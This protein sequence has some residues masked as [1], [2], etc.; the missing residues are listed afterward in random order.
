MKIID[1]KVREAVYSRGREVSRTRLTQ[2]WDDFM[3]Y[4]VLLPVQ[5]LTHTPI[6][7][8]QVS[9]LSIITRLLVAVC[10]SIGNIWYYA[11]GIVFI[12]ISEIGDWIDGAIARYRNEVSVL[13]CGF[14]CR[15]YHIGT[16]SFILAGVGIGVY[17]SSQNPIYLFLGMFSGIVQQTTAYFLELKNS[18]LL[19]NRFFATSNEIKK[20]FVK[21]D[22]KILGIFA[23]PMECEIFYLAII[24]SIISNRLEWFLLFYGLYLPS[25]ALIF[26]IGTYQK[27]KK[28]ER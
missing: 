22:K 9:A 26:F 15:M 16:L 27:L 13:R 20:N 25:R 5:I 19:N 21:K 10:F 3:R 18:L 24:I 1:E 8:N 12:I 23:L 7:G 17:Q 14:L 2:A 28:F 4:I 11:L 6:T